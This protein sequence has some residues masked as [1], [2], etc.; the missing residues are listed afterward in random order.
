M[1]TIAILIAALAAIGIVL[2]LGYLTYD[3][4]KEKISNSHSDFFKAKITKK[5]TTM[6]VDVID[7]QI[8]DICGRT[9]SNESYAGLDGISSD[10]YTNSVVYKNLLD[11]IKN[12]IENN[13]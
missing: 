7:V 13:F 4:I 10:L 8:E 3:K 2:V 6:G 11:D 9:I 5:Y 12:T 1:M